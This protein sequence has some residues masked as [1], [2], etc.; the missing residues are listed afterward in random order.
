MGSEFDHENLQIRV[1][2]GALSTHAMMIILLLMAMLSQGRV[3]CLRE[4]QL[5]SLLVSKP[6][7]WSF[8][9][10]F[11]ACSFVTGMTGSVSRHSPSGEF[12]ECVNG[13]LSENSTLKRGMK[14]GD[15]ILHPKAT[16]M[17][18]CVKSC[19]S[20]HSCEVVLFVK[21][22]CYEVECVSSE[23]C[24]PVRVESSKYKP[25]IFTKNRGKCVENAGLTPMIS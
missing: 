14:A 22:R 21:G 23:A 2:E 6:L 9:M 16:D 3:S 7:G 18:M 1:L 10:R 11:I 19:C 17:D 25:I 15:F 12:S 24:E 5:L 4:L 20:S 13:R 8:S